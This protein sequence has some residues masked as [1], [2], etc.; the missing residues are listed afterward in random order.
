MTQREVGAFTARRTLKWLLPPIAFCALAIAAISV[1]PL[2]GGTNEVELREDGVLVGHHSPANAASMASERLGFRVLT[3]GE[4]PPGMR[5]EYVDSV[6]PLDSAGRPYS[7]L[8]YAAHE[9]D[10]SVRVLRISQF[11]EF[12]EF[13]VTKAVSV[14]VSLEGV[15]VWRP[16][17][18][19]Q[20][21]SGTLNFQFIARMNGQQ[22]LLW[23]VQNEEPR[24]EDVRQVLR[25][26]R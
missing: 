21:A 5:L 23:Y 16:P 13:P 10:G 11:N 9:Q 7:E 25:T 12:V 17:S 6:Q 1:L 2:R 24:V 18:P 26:M 22:F 14:P 8:G 4:P 19:F 20:D 15:E 3:P